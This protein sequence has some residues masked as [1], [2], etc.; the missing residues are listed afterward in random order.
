MSLTATFQE[1]SY[2]MRGEPGLCEPKWP[3]IAAVH[4]KVI[5][6][7]RK[8]VEFINK[9]KRLFFKE[10]I[11]LSNRP[12]VNFLKQEKWDRWDSRHSKNMIYNRMSVHLKTSTKL[13]NKMPLTWEENLNKP[14][15][16]KDTEKFLMNVLKRGFTARQIYKWITSKSDAA[17]PLRVARGGVSSFISES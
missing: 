13:K 15:I 5:T 16:L 11:N 1:D 14:R 8:M 7:N 2:S 17:K 4:E 10:R 9:S 6:D 3:K 12:L